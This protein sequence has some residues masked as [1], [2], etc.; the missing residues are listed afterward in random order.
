[1]HLLPNLFL[2]P[3]AGEP[4]VW[5]AGPRGGGWSR[6]IAP[7]CPRLAPSSCRLTTRLGE[8]VMSAWAGISTQVPGVS[9]QPVLLRLCVW[10]AAP[11]SMDIRKE[12]AVLLVSFIG[13]HFT[14]ASHRNHV[15][16]NVQF[17]GKCVSRS[18]FSVTTAAPYSP[19]GCNTRALIH[20]RPEHT[21]WRW[22]RAAHGQRG[23]SVWQSVP[24]QKHV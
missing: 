9:E 23:E 7:G 2:S 20:P 1:M 11:G 14:H 15:P 12:T 4:W 16:R 21:P 24:R 17:R 19:T 13:Q 18:C 10:P 8:S 6:T 5:D 22:E 3:P